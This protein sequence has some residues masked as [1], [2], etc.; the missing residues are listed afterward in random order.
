MFNEYETCEN[1]NKCGETLRKMHMIYKSQ[2]ASSEG[3]YGLLEA[4]ILT[5]HNHSHN[6]LSNFFMLDRVLIP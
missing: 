2:H 4:L 3:I 1:I 6:F 5:K